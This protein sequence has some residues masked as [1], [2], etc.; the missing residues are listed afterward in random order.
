MTLSQ[1]LWFMSVIPIFK[2]SRDRGI[3]ITRQAVLNYILSFKKPLATKSEALSQKNYNFYI[4]DLE[5]NQP[6]LFFLVCFESLD[7]VAQVS[8]KFTSYPRLSSDSQSSCPSL[9]N[10]AVISMRHQNQLNFN[11]LILPLV[12]GCCSY[13]TYFKFS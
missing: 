5:L 12:L 3:Y 10:T 1:A 4:Y 8:L 6:I 13:E 9:L 11:S 2:C 7:Y